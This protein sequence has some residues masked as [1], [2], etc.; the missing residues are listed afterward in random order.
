MESKLAIEDL[1]GIVM[2]RYTPKINKK[3]TKQ[4][5]Q[6]GWG[7][8][9]IELMAQIQ[10][11]IRKQQSIKGAPEGYDPDDPETWT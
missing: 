8:R 11:A 2:P 5:A 4:T 6:G 9:D 3:K 10:R 1:E 7:E